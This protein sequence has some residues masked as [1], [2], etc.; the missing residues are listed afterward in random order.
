MNVPFL[1]LDATYLEL[2]REM[3]AAY[4]RV[5]DGGW[6]I[7][8]KECDAFEAEFAQYCEAKHCIGVANGLEALYILL[9]AFDIGAGD[10]VIVPASTF[11]ATWLAVSET[12][13]TPI[14][15][16]PENRTYNIDPNR[17]EAAITSRTKAIMPVH[18]YGMPADMDIINALAHKYDLKVIEDA[19]QGHGARYKGRRVGSLGDAAGFS[20]YPAK[21]LGA[22]GDGGAITTNDS[23]LADRVRLLRNYGSR[24]KYYN[25]VK[26]LNSR[27]DEIQSAFLRVKLQYL[28]E[29]NCR[30]TRTAEK[31]LEAF[32]GLKDVDLPSVPEWAEPSWYV[33]TIRFPYRD[34]L[35]QQLAEAG[36]GTVIYYPVPPHLSDAY[37]D[38][39]LTVDALPLC[40]EHCS[41][42][43]SLPIGPQLME[44]EQD[45]VIASVQQCLS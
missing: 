23:A 30:R 10:E 19:A 33:F 20:F 7:M 36:V 1:K 14:P 42:V 45:Y 44:A 5:M 27:L 38:M 25:E 16:E 29:W 43:L 34:R 6:Y 37:S 9:R 35:Q 39:G 11:I 8:G 13:A 21:N 15:V 22:Y 18:L 12:G 31:Y 4:H 40:S 26:G 2:R 17:I 32:Q 3:D 24:K 41:T 28:D